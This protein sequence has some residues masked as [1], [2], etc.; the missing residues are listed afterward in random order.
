MPCKRDHYGWPV[1]ARLHPQL[2]SDIVGF[3]GGKKGKSLEGWRRR[4]WGEGAAGCRWD[5]TIIEGR[6]DC[7][8]MGG[9]GSDEYEDE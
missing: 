6:W 5:E 4:R 1:V 3:E 7:G 2:H 9:R 8:N